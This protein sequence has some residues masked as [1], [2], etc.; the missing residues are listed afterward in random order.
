MSRSHGLLA[1]GIRQSQ[2]YLDK[3]INGSAK[4]LVTD[5]DEFSLGIG[6]LIATSSD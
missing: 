6:W 1:A 3:I 2:Y 4:S 5:D